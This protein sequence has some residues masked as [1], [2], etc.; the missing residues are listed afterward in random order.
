MGR[1]YAHAVM[2]VALLGS[3]WSSTARADTAAPQ[4]DVTWRGRDD[5]ARERFVDGL[6]HHLGASDAGPVAIDVEV[7][8]D[9][10]TWRLRATLV[11]DGKMFAT[12][13][14]SARS[15][16]AVSDAAALATA[17]AVDPMHVVEA[18]PPALEPG[19]RAPASATVDIPVP[20]AR[21][22][23][24]PHDAAI[25][26]AAAPTPTPVSSDGSNDGSRA[27]FA[28][29]SAS[30][31]ARGIRAVLAASAM[32]DA[33]ALPGVGVGPNA[34]LGLLRR[35]LRVELVGGWRAPV[36]VRAIGVRD[37]GAR[38]D[39]FTIG[40]RACGVVRPARVIE[41][42]LCGGLE[43]GMLRGRGFGLARDRTA[44]LPWSAVVASSGLLWVVSRRF[45]VSLRTEI[46]VPLQRHEFAVAGHAS[47]DAVA[48]VFGR[49]LLGLEVRS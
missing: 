42:P 11:A 35:R 43:T 49:G 19:P 32:V 24:P 12:R 1:S 5:C 18:E 14:F 45:A 29:R 16:E 7:T 30:T 20:L 48:P 13:E 28:R 10:T 36:V 31:R 15:C 34:S 2:A 40:A 25:V 26:D 17:I 23:P 37:E 21:D 3:A 6:A 39:L 33:G 38:V 44:R 4:V 47:F 22:V 46:G 27:P 41:L 8:G 9:A